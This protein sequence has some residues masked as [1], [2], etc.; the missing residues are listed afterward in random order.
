MNSIDQD[1]K[2]F[3]NIVVDTS[4]SFVD[5]PTI[6]LDSGT[7]SIIKIKYRLLGYYDS[8][9]SNTQDKIGLIYAKLTN[10][11]SY[12]VTQ[13]STIWEKNNISAFPSTLPSSCSIMYTSS[14]PYGFWIRI[15]RG[16]N[17]YDV[18]AMIDIT[19]H[20]AKPN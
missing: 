13:E 8:N 6:F 15:D 12:I 20:T 7:I 4:T 18:S 16:G 2:Y 10:Y 17:S 14:S 5:T 1:I 11:G 19:I 3:N 9:F